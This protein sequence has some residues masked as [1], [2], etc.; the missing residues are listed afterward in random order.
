MDQFVSL[1]EEFMVKAIVKTEHVLAADLKNEN[2]EE[3]VNQRE[4][5]FTI[6]DQISTKIEWNL[7]AEDKKNELN[8]QIEY[9]K[10]LDEELL[11]KLTAYQQELK[12]DIEK[13]FRQKENIK[14]YNLNDVK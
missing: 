9:I 10:K 12:K 14:G 3:F 4:K 7:V 8:R 6:I 5:L 13:T 2:L 1:L 11:V